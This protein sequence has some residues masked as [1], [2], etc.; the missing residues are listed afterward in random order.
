MGRKG[1]HSDSFSSDNTTGI[2]TGF[3]CKILQ[4]SFENYSKQRNFALDNFPI[5]T[6]WVFFLDADEWI[7]DELKYEITYRISNKPKENGFFI[8]FKFIWM[9]K[10]IRRGIYPTWILRLFRNNFARCEDRSVNEHLI[11]E[12]ECGYL[13]NDFIHEDQK[14]ISDWIAKHNKYAS[15]EANELFKNIDQKNIKANF[16][17]SQAERKRWLRYK[18]W[19]RLPPL[20]RPFFYFFYRYILQGG[21]LDGKEAFIYHILQAFWTQF[22]IDAKYL[23]MKR[24]K[25]MH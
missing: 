7:S 1:I 16:F 6:E 9:G 25:N 21:F 11:I 22:L 4:N 18:I 20:I 14:G 5:Q 12:G 15:L 3:D 13:Q 23:E 8:K 24:S 10:W 19:N 17:G 2:A